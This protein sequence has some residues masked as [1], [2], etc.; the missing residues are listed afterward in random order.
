MSKKIKQIIIDSFRG[1][2]DK[3]TFDLTKI[4]SSIPADLVVIH[5]PNGFG[6]TSFFESVEWCL[7]GKLSRIEKNRILKD[8]E[9]KDRGYTLTNKDSENLGIV[10]IIDNDDKKLTRKVGE[11]RNSSKGFR[12]YG[13]H[14]IIDNELESLTKLDFTSHILTQDGMDSFLRFT[15]SEE[16]FSALENFWK[17]GALISAKYRGLSELLKKILNRI[18]KLNAQKLA[19]KRQIEE[20]EITPEQLVNANESLEEI[21]SFLEANKKVKFIFTQ[22]LKTENLQELSISLKTLV[23]DIDNNIKVLDT[24]KTQVNNIKNELPIYIKNK[25]LLPTIH[26]EVDKY[27]SI[28]DQFKQKELLEKELKQLTLEIQNNSIKK[29]NLIRA[30]SLQDSYQHFESELLSTKDKIYQFQKNIR[31]ITED[32]QNFNLEL[33]KVTRL[34]NSALEE[35]QNIE[36]K[37]T[38]IESILP[39]IRN[40]E[41]E[42]TKFNKL[43]ESN[44]KEYQ[45][46]EQEIQKLDKQK[47]QYERSKLFQEMFHNEE[48]NIESKYLEEYLFVKNLYFQHQKSNDELLEITK[49]KQK[50]MELKNDITQLI[51]IG[52]KFIESN[53]ESVCPL[54]K[55]DHKSHSKLLEKIKDDSDDILELNKLE[56]E[57][58]EKNTKLDSILN[59]YNKRSNL[60][61]ERINLDY[62]N[63]LLTYENTKAKLDK[64]A[65]NSKDIKKKL[66]TIKRDLHEYNELTK[67]YMS[68]KDKVNM[69]HKQ[70]VE[71]YA[72][73]LKTDFTNQKEKLSRQ[74]EE[75]IKLIDKHKTS[76][77]TL[78]KQITSEKHSIETSTNIINRIESEPNLHEYKLLVNK[79]NLS[80]NS[81]KEDLLK[82]LEDISSNI[83][84]QSIQKININLKLKGFNEKL[85]NLECEK[86]IIEHDHVLDHKN[87]I[88]TFI[89]NIT[90]ETNTLNISGEITEEKL[91]LLLNNINED[92]DTKTKQADKITLLDRIIVEM[93]SSLEIDELQNEIGK[94]EKNLEQEDKLKAFVKDAADKYRQFIDATI[95]KHFNTKTINDIYN[96]VD[97]HPTH[98]DVKFKPE[99]ENAKTKLRVKTVDESGEKYDD[100]LLY[101]SSGQISILSLSIFLAKA[102][103]T[104]DE[105]DTIFL[106]DPIQYLDAVNVLSFIDL[107]RTIITQE[108]RQIVISTHDKNFYQLLQKKLDDK[109]YNSKFI[110]LESYGKIKE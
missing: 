87:E 66:T 59:E 96:R 102:L 69:S 79:L 107:L 14:Q 76:I 31:K 46:I 110:E 45:S 8:S 52:K 71:H 82:L 81:S 26:K 84:T 78:D 23:I 55:H 27:K 94:I 73:V 13:Y 106:D 33:T 109:Y 2:R 36:K 42:I 101:N 51:S 12:D 4:D 19:L 6:K 97:P 53:E 63:F 5:A 49:R 10:T 24:K 43:S 17:D 58:Q 44:N 77:E 9:E 3:A 105:L 21:N 75:M 1:Y 15:S 108:K 22:E 64:L 61:K 65:E 30:V 95:S 80:L 72:N 18:S 20:L 37:E 16:K 90:A 93:L 70:I 32:R 35:I 74:I 99:F 98:K 47:N 11:S 62:S 91:N 104:K 83:S 56:L 68:L 40:S 92:M 48:F 34:K 57:I 38:T 29:E 85:E 41:D 54:C 103:Q 50:T 86:V 39:Q 7:S 89:N 25:V 100:P 60:L 88:S 67:H 28:I